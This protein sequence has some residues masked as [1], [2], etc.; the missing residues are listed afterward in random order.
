[1]SGPEINLSESLRRVTSAQVYILMACPQVNFALHSPW[2]SSNVT[3]HC[4]LVSWTWPSNAWSLLPPL[5]LWVNSSVSML[6]KWYSF[7][8]LPPSR[9][10]SKTWPTTYII[11]LRSRQDMRLVAVQLVDVNL[12][13]VCATKS[14]VDCR[15][16]HRLWCL[17]ARTLPSSWP[18]LL[19]AIYWR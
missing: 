14:C 8:S 12:L 4:S 15:L 10:I 18:P 2:S 7:K 3:Q 1:M 6:W 17:I 5:D 19:L 16:F 9:A 11:Y 13:H